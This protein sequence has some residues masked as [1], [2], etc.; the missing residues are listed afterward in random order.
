MKRLKLLFY[1]FI[2]Y[3]ITTHAHSY[4]SLLIQLKSCANDTILLSLLSAITN[5]SDNP[6]WKIHNEELIRSSEK[7]VKMNRSNRITNV[8]RRY[9][10]EGISNRAWEYRR[11]GKIEAAIKAYM[12]AAGI[13]KQ[14][15]A[16]NDMISYYNDIAAIYRQ[17]GNTQKALNL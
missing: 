9:Y 6:D 1:F 17:T 14:I 15:G 10:A 11:T 3:S 5:H 7:L 2:S 4:D 12:E 13:C 16:N 8:A